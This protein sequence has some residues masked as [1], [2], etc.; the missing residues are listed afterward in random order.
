MQLKPQAV[1]H[2]DDWKEGIQRKIREKVISVKNGDSLRR[3]AFYSRSLS[4][5]ET[6]FVK[7]NRDI[8][9]KREL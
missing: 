5:F 4:P 9:S 3:S 8:F 7:T 6:L 2:G 1:V